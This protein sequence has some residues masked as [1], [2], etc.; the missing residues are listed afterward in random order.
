MVTNLS[1]Q[2][3]TVSP[4]TLSYMSARAHQGTQHSRRDDLEAV[5]YLL[6]FYLRG[7]NLPWMGIKIQ[8]IS[9]RLAT[10]YTVRKMFVKYKK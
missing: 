1:K 4:G 7:G 3:E 2:P 9:E 10:T 8:D 5:G 6:I